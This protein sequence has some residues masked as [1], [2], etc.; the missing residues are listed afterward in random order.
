M[1]T[2]LGSEGRVSIRREMLIVLCKDVSE[3]SQVVGQTLAGHISS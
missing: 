2:P 3:R 1:V